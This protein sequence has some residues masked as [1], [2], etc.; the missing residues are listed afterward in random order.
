[1]RKLLTAFSTFLLLF[2][3]APAQETF[4]VNGIA[5]KR[6]IIYAFTNATIYVDYKTV[7]KGA[8]LV[9][10]KDKIIAVGPD[11]VIPKEA[12]IYNCNGKYIYPSLIDIYADY[13]IPAKTATQ[14]GKGPQFIS[15]TP[16]AYHWNQAIRPETDAYRLFNL[17]ATKAEEW[18]KQ[19]F[20]AVMT[21]QKDGIARG[22]GTLVSLSDE[23]ENDVILSERAAACYSFEIGRAHV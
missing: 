23:N 15:N 4:P 21:H 20:G 14:R 11:I 1:M 13:G 5:D 12:V 6:D 17:D 19:G 8:T 9:V 2:L 10:Q 16:G 18:R 22:T 3:N 7:I